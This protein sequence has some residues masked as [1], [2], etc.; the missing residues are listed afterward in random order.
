MCA[1]VHGS[2]CVFSDRLLLSGAVAMMSHSFDEVQEEARATYHFRLAQISMTYD[3]VPVPPLFGLRL[4]W[5]FCEVAYE[6]ALRCMP[7]MRQRR[8]HE[9]LDS[10]AGGERNRRESEETLSD[11]KWKALDENGKLCNPEEERVA[12]SIDKAFAGTRGITDL[13]TLYERIEHLFERANGVN[14][15]VLSLSA[16]PHAMRM[17]RTCLTADL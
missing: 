14:L 4:P 3:E 12:L 17:A 16:S 15:A 2:R 6:F 7:S 9:R 8:E 11:W 5:M 13:T 1:R 10:K